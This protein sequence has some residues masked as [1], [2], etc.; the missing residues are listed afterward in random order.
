[1]LVRGEGG[2]DFAAERGEGRVA[3]GDG[4]AVGFVEDVGRGEVRGR[5][6]RVPDFGVDGA[7]VVFPRGGSGGLMGMGCGMG[8][9]ECRGE[10]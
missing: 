1:M 3:A 8:S 10:D 9:G 4:G 5:G 6:R 2:V 7:G